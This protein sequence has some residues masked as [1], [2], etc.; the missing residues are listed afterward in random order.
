MEREARTMEYLRA[1]GYP[2]PAVQEL[3][4]GG[5]E[6]VMERIDGPSMVEAI[7]RAPWTVRRQA[8]S[9]ADLHRRLHEVDPPDF[10][11]PAP[12]G[13]GGRVLH[14]DLHPLNVIIGAQG[15][16]VIDWTNASIGDAAVDVCLA[17]VL[18]AAGTIPGGRVRAGILGWGRTLLVNG[19]LG[20][21]DRS[22]LTR[23]LRQVV[24]WKVK[25]PNMSADE[26]ATMW[27]LVE[28]AGR[29]R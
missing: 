20:R 10:L 7:G 22:E 15:P 27:R 11:S 29:P 14:M 28:R 2:V 17:W 23:Q 25:D 6:L 12:V 24:E 19:F 3:G 8:W 5:T 26:V 4:S 18:M 16:V 1:Q 9:L 13:T 21:F